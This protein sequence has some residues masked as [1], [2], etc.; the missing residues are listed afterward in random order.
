MELESKVAI[1]TGGG[2]GIGRAI[3]L[4]LAANGA[5]VVFTYRRNVAA[6]TREFHRERSQGTLQRQLLSPLRPLEFILG[7]WLSAALQGS[8]QLLVLFLAGAILF[9]VN[10]GPDPWSLPLVVLLTCTAAAGF[11]LFL[12]LLCPNEKIADSLGTIV[13]LISAMLGGNMVPIDSLPEWFRAVGQF[14]FNYWANLSFSHI[15]V[16][17]ESLLE[18][19]LP[20]LVLSAATLGFLGGSLIVFIVR[21]RRGGMT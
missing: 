2:R 1:V 14:F 20:A 21:Q 9:Q 19:P 10:L 4:D 15:L 16:S 11:F 13:V 7:K 17:N 6:A 12:T 8:I 5:D 18:K 3:V